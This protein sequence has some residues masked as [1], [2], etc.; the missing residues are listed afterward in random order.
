MKVMNQSIP[1][2]SIGLPIES[3]IVIRI[4]LIFVFYIG[5]NKA[6]LGSNVNG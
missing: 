4:S 2:K 5:L 3:V 1:F 6:L